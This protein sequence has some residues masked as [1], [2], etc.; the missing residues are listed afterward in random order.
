MHAWQP[1]RLADAFGAVSDTGLTRSDI[2]RIAGVHRSQV[3]RWFRG[4]QRP[5]YDSAMLIAGYL[6]QQHPDL[7]DEFTAAAG[8]GGP[9][10]PAS[11]PDPVPPGLR[12]A[13][14]DELGA[15]RGEFVLEY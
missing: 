5:G 6:R 13:V 12:D 7:A 11:R 1:R 2:A 9:V 4:E 14:L 8:Y 15:G 10:D 3:S